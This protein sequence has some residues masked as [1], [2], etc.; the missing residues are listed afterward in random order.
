MLITLATRGDERPMDTA[1]TETRERPYLPLLDASFLYGVSM[2]TLRRMLR[3][4]RLKGFRPTGSGRYLV[5]RAELEQV[6]R[7]PG[8][9]A[10]PRRGDAAHGA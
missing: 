1:Q 10:A 7:G 5:S 2:S 8:G 4:G 6:L 3:D 9:P